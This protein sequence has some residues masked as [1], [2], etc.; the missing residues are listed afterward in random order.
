MSRHL[1]LSVLDAIASAGKFSGDS[2][3]ALR[4]H[5]GVEYIEE[6][7]LYLEDGAGSAGTTGG[8]EGK[9]KEKERK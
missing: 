1:D 5:P 6:N 8:T 7:K 2:L 4:H 3:E 9:G